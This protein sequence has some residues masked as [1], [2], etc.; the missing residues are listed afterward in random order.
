MILCQ[1]LRLPELLQ[2]QADRLSQFDIF[3]DVEDRFPIAFAD[4][5]MNRFVVVA[6]EEEPEAVFREHGGHDRR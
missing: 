4:V 6:V 3:C 1:V 2:L 5:D